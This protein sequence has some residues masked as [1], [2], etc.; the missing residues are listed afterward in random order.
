M[1]IY[2]TLLTNLCKCT[3]RPHYNFWELFC[4]A[5]EMLN[6]GWKRASDKKSLILFYFEMVTPHTSTPLEDLNESKKTRHWR[7]WNKM[8]ASNVDYHRHCRR[9]NLFSGLL[10][11]CS[12]LCSLP[13][14]FTLL[15]SIKCTI[16][17][18]DLCEQKHTFM[19]TV[20]PRLIRDTSNV[21]VCQQL[22]VYFGCWRS[23]NVNYSHQGYSWF[24][25]MIIS[26]LSSFMWLTKRTP[27]YYI[28]VKCSFYD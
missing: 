13:F 16:F 18:A 23:N 4:V 10:M 27:S 3:K 21:L 14:I 7:E 20:F 11:V 15:V 1:S 25:I 8:Y 28:H 12:T 9:I 17:T 5:N 26:L 24:F 2:M 19:K 6:T 22:P